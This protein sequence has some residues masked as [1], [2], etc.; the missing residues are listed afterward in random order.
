MMGATVFNVHAISRASDFLYYVF[1]CRC[2]QTPYP[3]AHITLSTK[4]QSASAY[5]EFL[6]TH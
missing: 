2:V 1:V 3:S 6:I 4:E 5:S